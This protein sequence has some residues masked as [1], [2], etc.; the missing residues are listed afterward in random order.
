MPKYW[1]LLNHACALASFSRIGS[2]GLESKQGR[3][4]PK[5][6]ETQDLPN[7]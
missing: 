3:E 6:I 5:R 7:T 2:R 4:L 1:A